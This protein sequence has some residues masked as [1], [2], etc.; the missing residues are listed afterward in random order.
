MNDAI[1]SISSGSGHHADAKPYNPSDEDMGK[2]R[3]TANI[4]GGLCCPSWYSIL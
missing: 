4:N 1:S 3:L 2:D